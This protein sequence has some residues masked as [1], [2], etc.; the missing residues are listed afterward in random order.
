M[1]CLV[2]V[3]CASVRNLSRDLC[4]QQVTGDA[5][6]ETQGECSDA[7]I[8]FLLDVVKEMIKKWY[9]HRYDRTSGEKKESPA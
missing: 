3:L 2:E 8:I 6:L 7:F 9:A 1:P 4:A 5:I